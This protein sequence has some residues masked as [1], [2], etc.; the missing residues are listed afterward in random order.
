MR[1]MWREINTFLG[2][3]LTPAVRAILLTNVAVF[4]LY[5]L[6]APLFPDSIGRLFVFLMQTPT[7]V[8][9]GCVWQL[10]TYMFMHANF[11]HLLFN[12]LIL[13]FFAPRL[14]YRWGSAKFL[15]FYLIVGIGAGLF[16]FG[17]SLLTGRGNTPLLGASG[18]MY[19]IMLAYALYWPND[20]VLLYFVVPVKIKYLMI[21]VGVFTFMASTTASGVGGISHITH[22]GGLAVALVYLMGG[23]WFGRGGPRRRRPRVVQV[24]PRRH[25]DFR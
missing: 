17:L 9:R 8:L 16:H 20:T 19:G 24:D 4:L 5:M 22:L 18:A 21:V 1:D 10:A 23:R 14:E 15:R 25:P 7:L 2:R 12:M 3:W 11:M 6:L 13:W